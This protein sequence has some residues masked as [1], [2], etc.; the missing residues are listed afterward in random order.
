VNPAANDAPGS[1]TPPARPAARATRSAASA[2]S[3]PANRT[4]ARER[5]A[6]AA[7]SAPAAKPAAA[8]STRAAKPAAAKPAAA[9]ES[10]KTTRAAK[11]AKPAAAKPAVAKRVRATET[12]VAGRA[13]AA[14]TAVAGRAKAA[15]RQAAHTGKKVA[16]KLRAKEEKAAKQA[17]KATDA[18]GIEAVSNRVRALNERIIAAGREAGETTLESYEKALKAIA[19]GIERGPGSSDIDWLANLARA[20]AKFLREITESFTHAARDLIKK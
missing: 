15:E 18:D 9:A 14:E 13:K 20:Q 4:P 10:A 17:G 12:A 6:A 5:G 11:P 1:E 7:K 19:R 8:K 2:K 16:A 3:A